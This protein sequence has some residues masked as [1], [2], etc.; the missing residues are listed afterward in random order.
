MATMINRG[1]ASAWS[2]GESAHNHRGNYHT[3]GRFLWSYRMLIGITLADGRKIALN[4]QSPHFVSMM[5]NQHTRIAKLHDDSIVNPARGRSYYRWD[6]W[7]FPRD[8]LSQSVGMTESM[9]ADYSPVP[10]GVSHE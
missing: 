5:T 10:E 7:L 3:D 1:V 4:A 9:L 2:R 6:M 8:L